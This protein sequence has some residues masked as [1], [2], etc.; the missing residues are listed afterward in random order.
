MGIKMLLSGASGSGKTWY[1]LSATK[2]VAI[3]DLEGGS[4]LY[5]RRK[6]LFGE[7]TRF[8]AVTSEDVESIISKLG[9]DTVYQTIV[10]DPITIYYDLLQEKYQKARADKNKDEDAS[11]AKKDWGDIKRHYK[12][13]MTKLRAMPQNIVLIAREKDISKNINGEQVIVGV[14]EDAERSTEYSFDVVLRLVAVGKERKMLV[15]KDRTLSFET[16]TTISVPQFSQWLLPPVPASVPVSVPASVPVSVPA[17]V[18]ASVPDQAEPELHEDWSKLIL[19]INSITSPFEGKNWWE[20]HK[21]KIKE[22]FTL[23]DAKDLFGKLVDKIATLKLKEK[24]EVILE[25][26]VSPDSL[27]KLFKK[28][29]R[30]VKNKLKN[31]EGDS[32]V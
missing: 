25:E 30:A 7:F 12:G 19:R 22:K 29:V 17:S 13:L 10:I 24:E 18:P 9:S 23:D 3:I 14:K 21:E 1:A 16:G 31:E 11:I 5:H 2:P 28:K 4:E 26:T 20:K 8:S 32:H 6:D 27:E 15:K